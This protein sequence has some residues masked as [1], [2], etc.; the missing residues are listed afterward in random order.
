MNPAM[1]VLQRGLIH[2][3]KHALAAWEAYLKGASGEIQPA[4]ASPIAGAAERKAG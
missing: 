2:A 4:K 3:I 1:V